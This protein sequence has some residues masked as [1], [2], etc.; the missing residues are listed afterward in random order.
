MSQTP[1]R[2]P[3]TQTVPAPS[4]AASG[5]TLQTAGLVRPTTAPGPPTS[6]ADG[7]RYRLLGELGRGGMGQVLHAYD[8]TLDR[9][10]A[11]KVLLDAGADAGLVARFLAEA[12]LT[13]QLQHPNIVPVYEVGRLGDAR[14]FF[15]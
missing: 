13:G 2:L 1:D 11:L 9:E 10:L 4:A 14:P 5:V 6:T 3:P 15:A 7:P 12:R 8:V